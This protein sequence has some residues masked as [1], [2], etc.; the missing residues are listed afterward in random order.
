M[1]D[2]PRPAGC[3]LSAPRRL[4]AAGTALAQPRDANHL[5]ELWQWVRTQPVLDLQLAYLDVASVGPTLRAAWQRN[6]GRANRKAS[7]RR[8]LAD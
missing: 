3:R 1:P 8:R 7:E 4:T 2:P 5:A 6:I